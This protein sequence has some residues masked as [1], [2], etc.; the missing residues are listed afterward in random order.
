MKKL[1]DIRKTL[2]SKICDFENRLE[3]GQEHT[4]DHYEELEK[5]I[6]NSNNLMKSFANSVIEMATE[7][8]K[9]P[10]PCDFA[11]VGIGSLGRGEATP[12]SDVEYL[13]LIK[14]PEQKPYFERLAV[15]T[16][17]LIGA[18]RETKLSSMDI[19][20][21]NGWFVDGR[22]KG[23]QIDGITGSSSNIP[24]YKQSRPNLFI[25]TPS[26]LYEAYKDTL[27]NPSEDANKGDMTAMLRFTTEIFSNEKRGSLLSE[28]EYG[29]DQLQIDL[30]LTRVKANI[31][32]LETDT[33]KH[34]FSPEFDDYLAGYS[35]T[36]K[37]LL[38]RHPS[39]ISADLAVI[40]AHQSFS[41]SIDCIK[42]WQGN[43]FGHWL[44]TLLV[45]ACYTRL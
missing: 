37:T 14:D 38:Y 41:S 10:A 42:S 4:E 11:A 6:L 33:S 45:Y 3:S 43:D 22:K 35:M 44:K 27:H 40:V 36:A 23:Y 13:F 16:Y 5:I 2:R 21:L 39:L 8:M 7:V 15:M 32:M 30:P 1:T 25:A 24:T 26:E 31:K 29:R 9:Q 12:F 17:F 34:E 28:F 18:L 20:E 19:D